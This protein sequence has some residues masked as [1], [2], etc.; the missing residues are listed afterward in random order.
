MWKSHVRIAWR[1]LVRYKGYSAINI[2]GLASGM[3]CCILIGLWILDEFSYDRFHKNAASIC[4]VESDQ[5]FRGRILHIYWTP[6]PLGP[7]LQSEI[8]QIVDSVRV[9]NLD[10]QLVRYREKTFDQ[11]EASSVDPSFLKMFSFPLVRGEAKSAL[12]G[13]RSVVLTQKTAQLIFGAEDPIGKVINATDEVDFTVT[14]VLEN[15]PRNSTLQFDMLIPY[16]AIEAAGHIDD[17]F[18]NNQ[19]YTFVQLAPQA[20][21]AGVSSIIRNFIPRRVPESGIQL[22]L[23]P[24]SRVHLHGYSGYV[25]SPLIRYVYMF[26]FV[27][28]LVLLVAC[29][30]FMNL[31]TARSANR[32]KEIAL[33][34]VVGADR[35]HLVLQFLG[36]SVLYAVIALFFAVGAVSLILPAVGDLFEKEMSWSSAGAGILVLGLAGIAVLTGLLS[37]S[38]PALLL[39]S[40]RPAETMKGQLRR[41]ASGSLFRR[42]LVVSQ[43]SMSV[44]LIIASGV[45]SKQVSFMKSTDMGWDREQVLAVP[46]QDYNPEGSGSIGLRDRRGLLQGDHEVRGAGQRHS[47]STR[48]PGHVTLVGELRVSHGNRLDHVWADR[49]LDG[50]GGPVH[51][52]LALYPRRSRQSG[53]E[54]PV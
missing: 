1:N 25:K 13:T 27:S 42:I 3:A 41:G 33:R 40:F 9:F 18:T 23:M 22:E 28:A 46:L 20:D 35:M 12:A 14:G 11:I 26:A 37:G 34:K 10:Q 5:N 31:S 15:V 47:G 8:P 49:R 4:R 39:T 17:S 21:A 43:F 50:G 2:V 16:K 29:I 52:E 54:P 44:A 38:Y 7:A 6:H 30:N 32:A 51:C 36:E 19:T 45:V 48:L 24:L 53:G